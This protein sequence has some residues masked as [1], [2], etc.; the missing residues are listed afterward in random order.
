M[1]PLFSDV[2]PSDF[3]TNE[4]DSASSTSRDDGNDGA[5]LLSR[6][7]TSVHRPLDDAVATFTTDS[8]LDVVRTARVLDAVGDAMSEWASRTE[9][10]DVVGLA[11]VAAAGV[12]SASS[13][14]F[15]SDSLDA[16]MSTGVVT[17]DAVGSAGE[18][19]GGSVGPE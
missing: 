7:S 19:A 3:G 15:A 8:P 11:D 13:G 1:L 10:P 9:T 2:S 12:A 17:G 4:P 16:E 14:S 18:L 5:S 6:V